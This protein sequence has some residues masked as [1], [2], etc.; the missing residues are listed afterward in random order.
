MVS[1]HH[2]KQVCYFHV[3]K[4]A[5]S[6]IQQSLHLFYGFANY[7]MLARYDL[8]EISFNGPDFFK[9]G[10]HV[11][12]NKGFF[13]TNPYSSKKI[14]IQKYFST[15]STL[16]NMMFQS[17]EKWEKLYK[18]TFVRDP[19]SRFISSWNYIINGFKTK[20]IMNDIKYT[21]ED[22]E[23]FSDIEYT[24]ENRLLLT[25][26]AYNHVFMTQYEHILDKDG[27]N[28]MDFIGKTETLEEDLKTVLEKLGFD[29]IKHKQKMHVNKTEHKDY[30]EY[31]NQSIL[32]FV[33]DF[34]N[35]DFVQFGYTK[36]ETLE[37]FLDKN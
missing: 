37:E 15:S 35:D 11:I 23:N 9:R 32:N 4:T 30:K 27:K 34:F 5:G 10:R 6:Y 16:L 13:A 29:E 19:Y 14:G 24:I 31:Y 21:K 26:I 33:N 17:E 20:K 1:I 22:I 36:Y 12:N 7:N 8:D 3:P 25:D 2:E 28:N 18:F